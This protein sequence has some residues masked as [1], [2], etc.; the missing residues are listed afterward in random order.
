[1]TKEHYIACRNSGQIDLQLA[2]EMYINTEHST[3]KIPIHIFH[4]L[5][6]QWIQ[7]QSQWGGADFLG[8]YFAYY[9]QKFELRE[10]ILKDGSKKFI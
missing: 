3:Q 10:L 5:F 1:M 9:D 8:N 7:F 6:P 2:W 4:Q